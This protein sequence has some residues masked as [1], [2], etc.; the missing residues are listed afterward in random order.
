LVLAFGYTDPTISQSQTI[1]GLGE[2][3]ILNLHSLLYFDRGEV[4][5]ITLSDLK[6]ISTTIGRRE[7]KQVIFQDDKTIQLENVT[8]YIESLKMEMEFLIAERDK[9]RKWREEDKQR[10]EEDR[11]RRQEDRRRE[12]RRR[13]EEEDRRRK[14]YGRRKRDES[15]Q[16]NS[17]QTDNA[18]T[19]QSLT[20]ERDKIRK[21]REEYGQRNSWR[22]DTMTGQRNVR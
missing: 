22:T 12:D 4:H 6:A 5:R 16:R 7:G 21:W 9:I 8:N 19:R 2:R 1:K 11:R 20:A 3:D 14:E 17:W 18:M 10:E 15:K 13:E